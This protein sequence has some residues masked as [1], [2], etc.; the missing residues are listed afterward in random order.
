MDGMGAGQEGGSQAGG[1]PGG[2]ARE[3]DRGGVWHTE[4]GKGN[5]NAQ[6]RGQSTGAEDCIC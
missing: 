5:T 3:S 1:A 6:R 2:V 4:R